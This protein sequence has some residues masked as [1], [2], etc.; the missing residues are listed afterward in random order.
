M[1]IFFENGLSFPCS[2]EVKVFK[3]LSGVGGH[4]G[5]FFFL[6]L[7]LESRNWEFSGSRKIMVREHTKLPLT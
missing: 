3:S 4:E 7:I 5:I 6:M 2:M 1:W